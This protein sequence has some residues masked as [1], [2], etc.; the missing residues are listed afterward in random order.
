[1]RKE[2]ILLEDKSPIMSVL[3]S[4]RSYRASLPATQCARPPDPAGAEQQQVRRFVQ[5]NPIRYRYC[6]SSRIESNPVESVVLSKTQ[7]ALSIPLRFRSIGHSSLLNTIL[8]LP[9]SLGSNLALSEA[10]SAL[11]KTLIS[12]SGAACSLGMQ[13]NAGVW[14]SPIRK[15]TFPTK[16]SGLRQASR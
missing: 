8:C 4:V 6:K 11:F 13:I 10:N 1:M 14:V 3:E 2:G 9:I 5:A 16:R 7:V 12:R 15:P